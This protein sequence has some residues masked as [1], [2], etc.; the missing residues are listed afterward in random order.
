MCASTVDPDGSMAPTVDVTS[1]PRTPVDVEA[2]G[3]ASPVTIAD[4]Q[5]ET[6]MRE[7]IE[8]V[9]PEHGIF[10]EEHGIKFGSGA[11]S[12]YMWVL[13]PIDGTKSFITGRGEKWSRKVEQKLFRRTVAKHDPGRA[14]VPYSSCSL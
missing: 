7:L 3:D 13:D 9:V 14:L 4:R 8:K 6:V 5:A 1:A 10:G 12:K 11:G 2:K